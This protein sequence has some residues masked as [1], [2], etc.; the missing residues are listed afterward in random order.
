M[1]LCFCIVPRILHTTAYWPVA[2]VVPVPE[3]ST[4][5]LL[6]R[7]SGPH[8]HVYRS[9]NR[10]TPFN[11]LLRFTKGRIPCYGAFASPATA[12]GDT[13]AGVIAPTDTLIHSQRDKNVT[14]RSRPNYTHSRCPKITSTNFAWAK[15]WCSIVIKLR[16]WYHL[17]VKKAIPM[18]NMREGLEWVIYSLFVPFIKYIVVFLHNALCLQ[19]KSGLISTR[20]QCKF[21]T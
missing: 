11:G 15:A 19:C 3:R 18:L 7:Y 1:S 5:G 9:G 14:H 8:F 10:A 6:A 21:G 16:L 4:V 20:P 17:P 12:A 2:K 13:S